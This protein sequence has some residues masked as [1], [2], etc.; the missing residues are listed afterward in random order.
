MQIKSKRRIRPAA[1]VE[2]GHQLQDH[3]H[4]LLTVLHLRLS[5]APS[6]ALLLPIFDLWPRSWGMTHLF[7]VEFLRSPFPEGIG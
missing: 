4:F 5:G 1:A 6:L 3:S 7:S 2:C